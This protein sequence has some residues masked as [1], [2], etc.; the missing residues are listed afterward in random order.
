MPEEALP[1]QKALISISTRLSG[2]IERIA[3]IENAYAAMLVKIER[4]E[5]GRAKG[6]S[7]TRPL[8][9]DEIRNLFGI[10]IITKA[11]ARQLLGMENETA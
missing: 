9:V 5:Q 8:T 10:G 2:T 4:M 1:I 6:P 7:L 3:E 11:E